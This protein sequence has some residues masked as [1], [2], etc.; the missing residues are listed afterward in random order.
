[1]PGYEGYD[2]GPQRV[3]EERKPNKVAK[4]LRQNLFLFLLVAGIILGVLMGVLIR[5]HHPEFAYSMTVNET[6]GEDIKLE[7]SYHQKKNVMYLG[8]PGDLF[9][10]M[11]KLMI[12]P[13]ITSSL[14]S[15]MAAIPSKASGRM[16]GFAVL[17]YMIT[18]G[19]TILDLTTGKHITKYIH[20]HMSF[21]PVVMR[22]NI[23]APLISVLRQAL[24]NLTNNHLQFTSIYIIYSYSFICSLTIRPTFENDLVNSYASSE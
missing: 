24:V 7:A 13:L 11:L 3:D 6:T 17:Y 22:G 21:C 12:I 23:E 10:R 1:M 8:F 19:T 2:E 5:K 15:G 14:I 4:F 16:G 18:T 20:V 9:L